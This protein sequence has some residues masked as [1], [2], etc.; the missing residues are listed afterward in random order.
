[1]NRFQVPSK[2][3]AQWAQEEARALA[4]A[5]KRTGGGGEQLAD[6]QAAGAKHGAGEHR[7]FKKSELQLEPARSEQAA[8]NYA[9]L[10]HP[11][12]MTGPAAQQ[13]A[14][15][16]IS[17]IA[18]EYTRQPLHS[19]VTAFR[20]ILCTNYY[21]MRLQEVA[22][23]KSNTCI[24]QYVLI[25]MCVATLLY[26]MT[27]G[28]Y[29]GGSQEPAARASRARHTSLSA[30]AP[31]VLTD[32]ELAAFSMCASGGCLVGPSGSL[33]PNEALTSESPLATYSVLLALLLC[34]HCV[35][36]SPLH[37]APGALA[38]RN[39]YREALSSFTNSAGMHIR[40]HLAF[41]SRILYC[42][43]SDQFTRCPAIQS[44]AL[45]CVQRVRRSASRRRRWRRRA[46][47]ASR[48]CSSSSASTARSPRWPSRSI[49]RC[50]STC[51][52]TSTST[53]VPTYSRGPTSRTWYEY[54]DI[55][56]TFSHYSS[57]STRMY[58][59]TVLYQCSVRTVYSTVPVQCTGHTVVNYTDE[60]LV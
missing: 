57:K 49:A 11:A 25:V 52:S 23:I 26:V 39:P 42:S 5:N 20:T 38:P 13:P 12:A 34:N 41:E 2:P 24:I 28:Q 44:P 27:V 30:S 58:L 36:R 31:V 32:V 50:C 15:G 8:R 17:S 35:R 7:V 51:C 9:L 60:I 21:F 56:V 55:R 54:I 33:L 22:L 6:G 3:L 43:H 37:A 59:Y 40:V 14:P 1:M 48:S 46:R 29:G 19:T 18:C 4:Q 10:S 47:R 53:S 16:F 45:H